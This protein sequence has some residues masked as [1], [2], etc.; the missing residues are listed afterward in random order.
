MT[1]R[2]EELR[3][4]NP[5]DG[6][7]ALAAEH[8]P[9]TDFTHGAGSALQ[10]AGGKAVLEVFPGAGVARLLTADDELI[11]HNL[12]GYAVDHEKGHV[13][14]EHGT[15][16]NRTRLTVRDDGRAAYHPVLSATEAHQAH[17]EN[18]NR[19]RNLHTTH[20]AGRDPADSPTR[21]TGG[22]PGNPCWVRRQIFLVLDV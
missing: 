14:F 15:P 11:L 7:G 22:V 1:E 18:T 21:S 4:F 3:A 8:Q 2:Y 19:A 13:V 12:P 6:S 9:V 16:D 20:P 5:T 17:P 10:I